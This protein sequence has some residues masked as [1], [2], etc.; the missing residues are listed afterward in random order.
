MIADIAPVVQAI[1]LR[2]CL[3]LTRQFLLYFR[4][5]GMLLNQVLFDHGL[6]TVDTLEVALCKLT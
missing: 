3:V 5:A 4:V 6:I 2:I 1:L